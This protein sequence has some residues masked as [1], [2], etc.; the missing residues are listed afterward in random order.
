MEKNPAERFQSAKDIVFDLRQSL[1]RPTTPLPKK[2]LSIIKKAIWVT[3]A[4]ILVVTVLAIWNV[5]NL[6]ERIFGQ[7]AVGKVQSLAVLPLK[8]LSGD[9]KQQYFADGMTEELITTLARIDS[10]HV[11]SRTSVMEYKN[12]RKPL[13]VIAK[14]L[15]VD[16]II[17]GSVMQADDR[18]RITAQLVEAQTDRHL[19][20]QSYERDLRD[21]LA[22]QNEVARSIANEIKIK[23]TPQE[24]AELADAPTV[25]P[26]AYQAY[27]RGLDYRA[28]PEFTEENM[29][30]A[31][32]MLERAVELDPK[33]TMAFVEL[34]I[35]NSRMVHYGFDHGD[36]HV[37]KAKAAIDRAFQLEPGSPEA[38]VALGYYHYWGRGNYDEALKEFDLAA[39]DL[40]KKSS[41][42]S[43]I[44]GVQRRKGHFEASTQNLKRLL[45]LNPRDSRLVDQL[46][47]NFTVTRNYGEA[48][49]YYERAIYLA[50]DVSQF[51]RDKAFNYWLWKGTTNLSG[52]TL[53]KMPNTLRIGPGMGDLYWQKIYERDYTAALNSLSSA[54]EVPFKDVTEFTS[55]SQLEGL[56]FRL[57]NEKL[58]AQISFDDARKVLEKELK[59]QF[60]NPRIHSS[61]GIV[62]AGLGHKNLAVHEG[63]LATDLYPVS[64]DAFEGPNYVINLA[65]IYVMVEE[66][67]NAFDQIEYLLSIPSYFSIPLLKLDPRWDPLRSHERYQKI[68]QKYP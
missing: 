49:T 28:Q 45:E 46:G 8:N 60:G 29:N 40:P 26:A 48:D 67:D 50:P 65:L 14:E 24:Q 16:V 59:S 7:R 37:K 52:S 62:Y 33:F 21:V 44:A 2:T 58:K 13:T 66:Y 12:V 19:W 30:I 15:N 32:G 56:A 18:V 3:A 42:L 20:A 55:R 54:T 1:T 53:K 36:E 22:L 64:K 47:Y 35:A 57:M 51:Y 23:L 31:V 41:L 5:V 4:L 17:D 6:R 68:L 10:L 63:K 9:P 39:R 38:H 61:L 43:G 34:S 11:I 25:Y 27:L